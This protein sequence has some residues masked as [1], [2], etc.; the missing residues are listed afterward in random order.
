MPTASN[1]IP[2][3][4]TNWLPVGTLPLHV[5]FSVAWSSCGDPACDNKVPTNIFMGMYIYGSCENVKK[6]VQMSLLDAQIGQ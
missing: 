3:H 5:C 4:S 6:L 2:F 1:V